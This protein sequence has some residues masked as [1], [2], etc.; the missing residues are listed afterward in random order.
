MYLTLPLTYI[1]H[2]PLSPTAAPAAQ[3]SSSPAFAAPSLNPTV[4]ELAKDPIRKLLN[5]LDAQDPPKGVPG[6]KVEGS[7]RECTAAATAFVTY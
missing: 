6:P 1:L 7:F 5:K 3:A 4:P 2:L